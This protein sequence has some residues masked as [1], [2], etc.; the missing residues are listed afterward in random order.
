MKN[1]K[2]KIKNGPHGTGRASFRHFSFS[3]FNF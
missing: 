3:I 1:A 2:L